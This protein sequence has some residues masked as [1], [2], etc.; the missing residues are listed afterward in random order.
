[1]RDETRRAKKLLAMAEAEL[2][3]NG[4][5]APEMDEAVRRELRKQIRLRAALS[6]RV[7]KLTTKLLKER[8]PAG[9]A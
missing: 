3:A 1:M 6:Q 2:A 7:A 4:T 9:H 5:L 8:K